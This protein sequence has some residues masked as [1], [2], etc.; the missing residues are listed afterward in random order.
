MNCWMCEPT[1]K[2]NTLWL[3]VAFELVRG[4]PEDSLGPGVVVH[5]LDGRGHLQTH[6]KCI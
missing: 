6:K 2:L 3:A 1:M 4:R 5:R